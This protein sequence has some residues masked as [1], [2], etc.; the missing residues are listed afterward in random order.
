MSRHKKNGY[1]VRAKEVPKPLVVKIKRR[2]YFSEVD[3]LGIV[4][5]GR[6]AQY[7]EEAAAALGRKCGLSY[8]DFYRSKLAAPIVEFHIDYH[9][10]LYL[11]EEFTVTA[12]LIWNEGSRINIE[13][14]L[15]KKDKGLAT[16]GYTVQM[17]M[18]AKTGEVY[19]NSP[20]LLEHCRKRWRKGEFKCPE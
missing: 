12:S 18:N 7:F 16:S 17:F 14:E 8:R 5:Y 11:D 4:W 20:A 15:R 19:L 10:P 3:A 2:A 9:Q 6:Y 1:F 13:F